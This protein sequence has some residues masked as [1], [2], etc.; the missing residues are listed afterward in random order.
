MYTANQNF[1]AMLEARITSNSRTLQDSVR[2]FTQQYLLTFRRGQDNPDGV[3]KAVNIIV[4][5]A[6]IEATL[7]FTGDN[8]SMAARLLG[9]SRGTL[10]QRREQFGH[11]AGKQMQKRGTRKKKALV[12]K[13]TMRE[14]TQE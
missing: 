10:R 6:I 11:Y 1:D 5:R 3:Y 8:E 7:D 14:A 13:S 12:N 2:D 4:D 9:M